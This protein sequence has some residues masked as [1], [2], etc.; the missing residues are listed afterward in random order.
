MSPSQVESKSLILGPH[1]WRRLW[2]SP[3]KLWFNRDSRIGKMFEGR[4]GEHAKSGFVGSSGGST[5]RERRQKR[6]ENR[7]HKQQGEQSS[8][9]EGS[10]QTLR[11]ISGATGHGKFKERDQEVE[12]LC[13]LVRDLELGARDRR[14]KRDQNNQERRDDN[15]GDCY[16]GESCQSG[17]CQRRDHS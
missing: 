14:Q 17:S 2:G 4:S 12:R 1:N 7:E 16:G 10:Y 8:L 9:G 6:R 5:W 13:R 11:T 15:V 3:T